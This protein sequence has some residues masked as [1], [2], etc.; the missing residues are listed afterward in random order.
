MKNLRIFDRR[1]FVLILWVLLTTGFMAISLIGYQV[2]RQAIRAAIIDQDLPLTSSN[3]YSEIQKDLVRPVLISS[4]MAHDTF[5]RDWVLRGEKEPGEM[6]RYLKEVKERHGA[7][8][9]FFI[10]EKTANYYTGDGVLKRISSFEPRD[11]WYSRVRGMS[12]DYEINIDPDLANDDA[13]TIF[14]NYR[15]FDYNGD[16]IGAT[17]I[18]LTVDA[19]QRLIGEYQARFNRT[20]YFA[21]SR[22]ERVSLGKQAQPAPALRQQPGLGPL[23]DRILQERHGSYQYEAD[24]DNHILHVNYLP[25]IKWYLFVEQN[26]SVALAGIRQTLYASLAI[27]LVVTLF[28]VILIHVAFSRYQ[29]RIEEM[30]STDKLTGLLNRHAFTILIDKL[31]AEYRRAPQPIAV[32]L[33]DVDHFKEIND[34][35]G[36][37]AGD[38]VLQLIAERLLAGLRA[39]DIAARWGGEEFLMVMKGCDLTEGQRIAETLRQKIEAAAIVVNGQTIP[40]TISIGVSQYDGTELP[41]LTV[42]RA[43][44]ALYEAKNAG[45][46]RVKVA[47]QSNM[48]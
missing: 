8:S 17:G 43:D 35:H 5:M 3:I 15:V 48:A 37:L 28:V 45:R 26:E 18:G 33:A 14:I 36:H 23:L 1:Q 41:D 32:L 21:N 31:L 24:G 16:Y 11:A 12:E 7:F 10:S 9:S 27:S 22:G 39:S 44:A 38:Q 20:I 34:R 46:N 30:A 13:L 42:N 25:E 4:T 2:S 47:T 40:V 19:V 29:L 6:A